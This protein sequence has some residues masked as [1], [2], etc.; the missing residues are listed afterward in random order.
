MKGKG[1][2]RPASLTRRRRLELSRDALKF[3]ADVEIEGMLEKLMLS[4]LMVAAQVRVLAN[5]ELL[6]T[7]RS[8]GLVSRD[9]N[10]GFCKAVV[11]VRTSRSWSASRFWMC[12]NF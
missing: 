9:P 12:E 4:S 7:L 3:A 6:K 8:K 2:E 5:K 11:R 1:D 10:R